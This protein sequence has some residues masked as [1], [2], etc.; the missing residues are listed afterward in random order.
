MVGL[1]KEHKYDFEHMLD[2]EKQLYTSS[3][4]TYHEFEKGLRLAEKGKLKLGP[5]ITHRFKLDDIN[6][7]FRALS[8]RKEFIIK[9][10]IIP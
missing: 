2:N 10:I 7:A 3:G 5:L 4:C 8:E 6:K 9:A 1:H